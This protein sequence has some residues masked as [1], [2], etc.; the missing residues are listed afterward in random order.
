MSA[1]FSGVQFGV[2]RSAILALPFLTTSRLSRDDRFHAVVEKGRALPRTRTLRVAEF[3]Q[4]FQNDT[5]QKHFP[6]D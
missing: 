6:E 5:E 1:E 4:F 3:A 2:G